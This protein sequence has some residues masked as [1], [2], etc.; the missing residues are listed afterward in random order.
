MFTGRYLPNSDDL[1]RSVRE[2][3]LLVVLLAHVVKVSTPVTAMAAAVYFYVRAAHTVVHIS[4]FSLFM[5]R[6]I[7]FTVAWIAWLT[8]AIEVLRKS[9]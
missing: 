8:I 4:G 3:H 9:T 2:I 1:C 7:L 5:A 6:T